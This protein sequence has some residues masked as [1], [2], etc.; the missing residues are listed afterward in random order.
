MNEGNLLVL[1]KELEDF[2]IKLE[3]GE[4]QPGCADWVVRMCQATIASHGFK[5]RVEWTKLL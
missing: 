3:N 4:I 1:L 5:N 2:R